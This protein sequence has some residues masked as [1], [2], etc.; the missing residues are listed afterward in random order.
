[1]SVDA[2]DI[3]R[4]ANGLALNVLGL[5]RVTIGTG[6]NLST[7]RMLLD[8]TTSAG[9]TLVDADIEESDLAQVVVT[10][11]AAN[12]RARVVL[13]CYC[14]GTIPGLDPSRPE[15]ARAAMAAHDQDCQENP[16]AMR[17]AAFEPFVRRIAAARD[18]VVGY[19][20]STTDMHPT[21]HGRELQAELDTAVMLLCDAFNAAEGGEP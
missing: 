1:M 9:V 4:R 14:G 11:A 18:A 10:I 5:G 16:V 13:C 15:E 17:L 19:A 3:A 7:G 6:F 2:Q 8:V 20:A 12:Q 21:R